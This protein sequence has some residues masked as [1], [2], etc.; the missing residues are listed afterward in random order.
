MD[1]PI[2]IVD[3]FTD[4][5]FSGNPAAVCLLNEPATEEWMQAVAAEMNLSETAFLVPNAAAWSLRWFTPSVEVDLCG[6]ATLAAAHVLFTTPVA[7]SGSAGGDL[8]QFSTRSGVLTAARNGA[9]ISM[10]FPATPARPAAPPDALLACLLPGGPPLQPV[11]SARNEADW[12]IEL[13]GEDAVRSLQPDFRALAGFD[14]R[15]VIVTAAAGARTLRTHP[16]ADFVS[17]FFGPAVGVDEDPVTGSAHCTLG[18]WWSDRLERDDL[19]GLQL[20][21]RGGAVEVKVRGDRVT[22]SGAAVTVLEGRL[23]AT[24]TSLESPA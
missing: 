6:H 13:G 18:P 12:L 22:L 20:S 16:E 2:F 5:A 10:D 15:G 3:S 4:R 23:R 21:A 1:V 11:A 24:G 7:D 14:A 8:L 9:T 19:T 17:R